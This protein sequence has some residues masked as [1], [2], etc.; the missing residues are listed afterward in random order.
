MYKVIHPLAI[1]L[2][3]LAVITVLNL[4]ILA[5]ISTS[6]IESA[7][8]KRRLEKERRSVFLL[9]SIVLLFFVCHAG[10][11]ARQK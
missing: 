10:R 9:I 1:F 7:G 4:R 8:H 5:H 2:I 11:L 3:P 6:R